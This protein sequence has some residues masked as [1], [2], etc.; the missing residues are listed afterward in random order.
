MG[1]RGGRKENGRAVSWKFREDTGFPQ[2]V[3][4]VLAG[5]VGGQQSNKAKA[6]DSMEL[7]VGSVLWIKA[8]SGPWESTDSQSLP[9]RLS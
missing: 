7:E 9:K 8:L 3:W 1:S 5:A 2:E 4:T 6:E